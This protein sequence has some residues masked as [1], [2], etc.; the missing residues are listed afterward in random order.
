[1]KLVFSVL[2]VCS[3]VGCGSS[4]GSGGPGA[5]GVDSS[6]PLSALTAD[7]KGKLCDWNAAQAG[8]YGKTMTCS[9]GT[10]AS[11]DANQAECVADI[12]SCSATVG[13]FETCTMAVVTVSLCDQ[14]AKILT[15]TECKAVV[16]C[17]AK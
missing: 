1:M 4:G 15:A 5:S 8:G 12:P 2:L 16:A 13:Q 3:V 10:D 17:V 6:K 9:D 7:E 14:I 11:N